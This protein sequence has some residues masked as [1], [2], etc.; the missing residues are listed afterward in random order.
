[1]Y[2]DVTTADDALQLVVSAIGDPISAKQIMTR[3]N[4]VLW[5]GQMFGEPSKSFLTIT[6]AF[7]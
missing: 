4:S 7:S 3:F 5:L 1:V 6:K 2:E